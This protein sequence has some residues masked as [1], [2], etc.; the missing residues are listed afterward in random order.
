MLDTPGLAELERKQISEVLNDCKGNRSQAAARLGIN[1]KTLREKIRKYG[2]AYE[3]SASG[4][5][6]PPTLQ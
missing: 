2:I 3:Q 1:R 6:T 4:E 5:E